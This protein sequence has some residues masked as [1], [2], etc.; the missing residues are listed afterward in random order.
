MAESKLKGDIEKINQLFFNNK[1]ETGIEM[2]K[3]LHPTLDQDEE[4]QCDILKMFG[5]PMFYNEEFPD[6]YKYKTILENWGDD[7]DCDI[8]AFKN[9]FKNDI[10]EDEIRCIIY[11][12]AFSSENSA[13]R[14]APVLLG[15]YRKIYY[16]ETDDDI[17]VNYFPYEVS[18]L[19]ESVADT[20]Y[21][22]SP[23]KAKR[24]YYMACWFIETYYDLLWIINTII[25]NYQDVDSEFVADCGNGYY[26]K[27]N[28][29]CD[30]WNMH[31]DE[32]ESDAPVLGE[33][34]NGNVLTKKDYDDLEYDLNIQDFKK[35][36]DLL[37]ELKNRMTQ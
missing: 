14:I 18:G 17:H 11:K 20:I 30:G 35:I 22:I 13:N 2:L 27:H 25:K 8:E 16:G 5:F 1:V 33:D 21:L 23:E 29:D 32:Y 9:I 28:V 19:L 10:G 12:I 24:F 37:N 36:S 15:V 7:G 6:D 3:S 4:L 26:I 34:Q 31:P